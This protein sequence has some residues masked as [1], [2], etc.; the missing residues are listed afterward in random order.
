M[1]TSSEF[2]G[3]EAE[4]L[5]FPNVKGRLADCRQNSI[6][7]AGELSGSNPSGHEA[8]GIEIDLS[9]GMEVA[10]DCPFGV[11]P[12]CAKKGDRRV[13]V[14]DAKVGVHDRVH[15]KWPPN[16]C[17]MV[18]VEHG[19]FLVEVLFYRNGMFDARMNEEKISQPCVRMQTLQKVH[20]FRAKGI[21]ERFPEA[22]SPTTG[23]PQCKEGLVKN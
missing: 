17:P 5:M 3:I 12:P 19:P 13:T 6:S 10:F 8:S 23:I 22:R 21:D 15:Q 2:E 14:H 16:P 20:A 18:F 4:P 11:S 1:A 9:V 7:V